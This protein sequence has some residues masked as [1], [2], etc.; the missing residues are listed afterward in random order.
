MDKVTHLNEMVAQE[1]RAYADARAW[2]ARL[3]YIE[4][5]DAQIYAVIDIPESDHPDNEPGF[6][7]LA[8]VRENKVFIEI[9]NTDRPLEEAFIKAGVHP[10][11]IHR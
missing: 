7:V 4:D 1:V 10:E 5:A 6:V 8:K 2:K 9:D 11:A 3:F